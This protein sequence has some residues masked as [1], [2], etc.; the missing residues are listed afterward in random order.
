MGNSVMARVGSGSGSEG[1]SKY[2]PSEFSQKYARVL[3]PNGKL[4]SPADVFGESG[5]F[6]KDV[7]EKT[8]LAFKV[9]MKKLDKLNAASDCNKEHLA[10]EKID[11]VVECFPNTLPKDLPDALAK[12][13]W[14][15]KAVEVEGWDIWW[16]IHEKIL[17]SLRKQA[18]HIQSWWE[19]TGRA[20][21]GDDEIL[22]SLKRLVSGVL[23]HPLTIGKVIVNYT[24]KR[25]KDKP[26]SIHLVGTD[27]PEATMIYSGFFT[28]ILMANPLN[29]I[30][31]T[32]VSPDPANRQL[33]Q[34]CSPKSPMLINQRCKLT[35]W[36]GF[37]HDFWTKWIKTKKVEVPDVA[38]GIHPG[39]H[40]EGVFEFWEPTLD[41]L[42][43][44]NILTVFT[45]FNKEE[46]NASIKC[47]D[48]MYARYKYKGPNA[49]ASEHVK[50]TPHDPDISWTSNRYLIV[51]QGRTVDMNTMIRIEDPEL[52]KA[53]EEFEK[54]LSLDGDE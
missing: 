21:P 7:E 33:A 1:A 31:I 22:G 38:M 10:R 54:L 15:K 14:S 46:F 50:Q 47:L 18:T 25:K 24:P 13:K 16:E 29:P 19:Y 53:E 37:Y 52:D 4:V 28:E 2:P 40:A 45:M 34:D 51:F 5:V 44:E 6:D 12:I 8:R 43:E 26:K 41:L 23:T 36:D 20:Y 27:R 17:K 42:M 32:L 35:A 11:Q 48:K 49:F 3:A 39:L 9:T 30:K